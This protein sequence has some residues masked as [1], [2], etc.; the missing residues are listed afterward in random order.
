MIINGPRVHP[1]ANYII[2]DGVKTSLEHKTDEE[3]MSIA[4]LLLSNCENKQVLRHLINGDV[5]MF[6]R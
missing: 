1:G 2:E 6:N 4:N 5:L 3:R